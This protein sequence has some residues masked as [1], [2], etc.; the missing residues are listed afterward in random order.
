VWKGA[1]YATAA[2]DIFS[3][4]KMLQELLTGD[5]PAPGTEPDPH[6]FSPVIRKAIRAKPSD[7]Y[8]SASAFMEDLDTL[9]SVPKGDWYP[10]QEVVARLDDRLR[11]ADPDDS[12]LGELF[13]L[14]LRADNDE[15]PLKELRE[16]IPLLS[17]KGIERL[18]K[19]DSAGFRRVFA[20]YASFVGQGAYSLGFCD[21]VADFCD[22]AVT[23][24]GDPDILRA[25]VG[26]LILLAKTHERWRLQ[27]VLLTILQRIRTP[28]DAF[29]ALEGLGAGKPEAIRWAFTDFALRTLHPL[30][31]DGIANI[32]AGADL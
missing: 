14:A 18:W 32:L 27:D 20:N 1:K 28:D 17:S 21:D 16:V 7:R 10:S 6:Q 31:K 2:A 25:A 13:D 5:P 24:T 9:A 19:L 29:A 15:A 22:R 8:A 30:L 11:D 26:A 23:V 3:L 12:V 4:G